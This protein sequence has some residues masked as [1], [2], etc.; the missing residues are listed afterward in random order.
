MGVLSPLLPTLL[1]SLPPPSPPPP[2]LTA[3]G[4]ATTP[5]A[6]CAVRSATDSTKFVATVW[7]LSTFAMMYT[8]STMQNIN[9]ITS[10]V[11]TME[12]WLDEDEAADGFSFLVRARSFRIRRFFR[13][14]RASAALAISLENPLPLATPSDLEAALLLRRLGRLSSP[15]PPARLPSDLGGSSICDRSIAVLRELG[16]MPLM[17]MLMLMMSNWRGLEGGGIGRL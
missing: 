12:P 8:T 7:C 11:H 3:A 9:P 17:L 2:R 15:L 14:S 13:S 10:T 1:V 5:A 16:A 4:T 6:F